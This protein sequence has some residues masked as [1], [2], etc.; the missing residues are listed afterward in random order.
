MSIEQHRDP[1][2]QRGQ[3]AAL[4]AIVAASGCLASVR[5]FGDELSKMHG[6]AKENEANSPSNVYWA[7]YVNAIE[8]VKQ[9]LPHGTPEAVVKEPESDS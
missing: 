6:V 8:R 3:I 9:E 5:G 4:M 2:F 1:E 7:G